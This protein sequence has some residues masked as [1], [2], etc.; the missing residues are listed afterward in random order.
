MRRPIKTHQFT[1]AL[2]L[3]LQAGCTSTSSTNPSSID[4]LAVKSPE[5]FLNQ[6]E[7]TE[8][9]KCIDEDGKSTGSIN[10]IWRIK[11][12]AGENITPYIQSFSGKVLSLK[13]EL[14]EFQ[15]LF[16]LE[17]QRIQ[18]PQVSNQP[19]F[20]RGSYSAFRMQFLEDEVKNG[21]AVLKI[22]GVASPADDFRNA[23]LYVPRYA[24][25]GEF[26]TRYYLK[27]DDDHVHELS[28]QAINQNTR[29]KLTTFAAKDGLHGYV[30][31]RGTR[32]A[33]VAS[34]D[35]LPTDIHSLSGPMTNKTSANSMVLQLASV[36]E[37][38]FRPAGRPKNY[39]ALFK[40]TRVFECGIEGSLDVIWRIADDKEKKLLPESQFI[41]GFSGELT[42]RHTGNKIAFN[43]V[44]VD[45]APAFYSGKMP[46]NTQ[47]FFP[48]IEFEEKDFQSKISTHSSLG[49]TDA[50]FKSGG[51]TVFIPRDGSGR[52]ISVSL[53]T[54]K[55]L[56]GDPF[57]ATAQCKPVRK[58]IS[59]WMNY[60]LG[61]ENRKNAGASCQP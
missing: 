61:S 4:Q 43:S 45:P 24:L 41:T 58:N 25:G 6:F 11:N 28:C 37:K 9:T 47:F 51:G 35:Q 54:G 59:D 16:A 18:I 39:D 17:E 32:V 7:A 15:S 22:N 8:L 50:N 12:S 3:S 42:D 56:R 48:A 27:T 44:T 2:L 53:S 36:S 52:A 49:K 57:Q 5:R 55:T 13:G 20:P 1:L 10:A 21:L 34:L 46:P 26:A 30:G 40:H 19:S 14:I 31:S 23:T 29:A 38:D 33:L 60:C